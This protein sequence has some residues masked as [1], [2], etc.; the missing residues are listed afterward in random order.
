[1]NNR[2]LSLILLVAII[3][4]MFVP[5]ASA[6]RV[7]LMEQVKEVE[8]KAWY[9]GGDPMAGAD[10]MIYTNRSGEKEL[11][12]ED[13]TDENGLYYFSP[14]LGVTQYQAVVSQMGHRAEKTFDLAGSTA[15]DDGAP[16]EAELPLT[17][18]ILAGF[19]YLAGL[20][21]VG[22]IITARRM[23]KQCEK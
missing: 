12:I 7:Y 20:A 4:M 1:M 2:A 14:Q 21:G 11:Y 5:A 17:A 13:T 8:I 22:M 23:K 15:T 18:R 3:V 9:G 10:I 6:H 16:M 19:G